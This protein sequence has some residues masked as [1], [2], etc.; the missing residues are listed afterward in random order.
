[1]DLADKKASLG[2][3]VGWYKEAAVA[4]TL[5]AGSLDPSALKQAVLGDPRTS[6]RKKECLGAGWNGVKKASSR[7]HILLDGQ[8]SLGNWEDLDSVPR[9]VQ[10]C[11]HLLTSPDP[12]STGAVF[13]AGF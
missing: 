1:M 5:P 12:L 10:L 11:G 9:T 3:R 2:D 13:F 6:K 7:E 8:K 4:G